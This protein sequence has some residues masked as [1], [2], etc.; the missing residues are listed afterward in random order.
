MSNISDNAVAFCSLKQLSDELRA[1]AG[2]RALEIN[3]G[4]GR[5]I[6]K[7]KL[8]MGDAVIPPAELTLLVDK[9]WGRGGVHLTVG[10]LDNPPDDLRARILL[11]MNAWN[12]SANVQFV[13]S[14]NSPQV[15]INRG[16]GGYWSYHGTDILSI[17]A[18]DPTMN[19]EGFTMNTPDSEF[20]RVVR[21]ETGHTL[22]FPHEHKRHQIVERI[23]RNQAIAFFKANQGWSEQKT[24]D[25]VLTALDESALI[26]TAQT[27]MQSIMC[28]WLPGSIMKDGIAVTGGSD[29]DALDAQFAASVYPKSFW[30]LLPGLGNDIG[31]G[32]D[33]SAWVIGTNHVGVAADFGV[34]KWNGASWDGKGG[35]G[36]RISVGPDGQA[37]MVNSA[38]QIFRRQGESWAQLPGLGKDIGVGPDGSVWLLG[39]NHVGAAADFGIYKWNGSNWDGKGGGGVRIAVGPNGQAWLVNSVGQIFRSQGD[40]WSLLPGL[41]KDIGVGA[42]GSV[43][44]IGTNQVGAAADFGVYKWNGTNWDNKGGGGV[45]ISVGPDGL[46]W[47]LN[48]AGQI[49][50]WA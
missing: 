23:D 34:Y 11:H 36:I 50:H 10:F 3:P 2:A 22:G 7:L 18:N 45:A 39:T 35:G 9:Y 8:A 46:P 1:P 30:N 40:S 42:D 19:L 21:H 26:G 44:L 20:H 31:V 38:G 28:Y 15:R 14:A 17:G 47:L 27:D 33:G 13:A 25:Q 12:A 49:F 29:I 41:G 37:W 32:A 5:V 24:I 48:S 43:W 6:H 4:N 16:A